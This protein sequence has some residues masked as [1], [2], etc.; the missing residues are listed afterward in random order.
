MVNLKVLNLKKAKIDSLNYVQNCTQLENIC[1][2]TENGPFNY[3]ILG[4]LPN[5]KILD[6][7]G[8]RRYYIE[9]LSFL[10]N[11]EELNLSTN[12][13]SDIS[14]LS[15]MKNL[16]RLDVSNNP[17]L[18]DYHPIKDF[19]SLEYLNLDFNNA[20]DFGFFE[21]LPKLKSISME[22]T[23]FSDMRNLNH[24]KD[25]QDLN[26]SK[27]EIAHLDEFTNV[28]NLRSFD[29]RFCQLTD[30]EFLRHA[31]KLERLNLFTN[32]ITSIEPLR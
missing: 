1:V 10:N 13:L 26:V 20:T 17:Y 16:R 32:R 2:N 14:P 8:M 30:I 12:L 22:Q 11:I 5:L 6:M 29:A 31:E 4:R 27:N 23:G 21:D 9:D 3:S 25:L 18:V 19:P 28:K 15:A 24:I 7:S